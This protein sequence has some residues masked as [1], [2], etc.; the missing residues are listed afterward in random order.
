MFYVFQDLII[1]GTGVLLVKCHHLFKSLQSFSSL[2][3][4]NSS[5]AL[6]YDLCVIFCLYFSFNTISFRYPVLVVS[7]S[8]ED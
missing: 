6:V 4:N 8:T 3:W 1:R 5:V 7:K 2:N